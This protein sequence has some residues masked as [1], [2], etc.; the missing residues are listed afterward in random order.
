MSGGQYDMDPGYPAVEVDDTAVGGRDTA[1]RGH[2]Y[3]SQAREAAKSEETR[4][5]GC[6]AGGREQVVDSA[7][8]Y[9]R[10]A[11]RLRRHGKLREALDL[12][13]RAFEAFPKDDKVE[14]TFC[15][16]LTEVVQAADDELHAKAIG[17][18]RSYDTTWARRLLAQYERPY[19]GRRKPRRDVVPE[20]LGYRFD[21]EHSTKSPPVSPPPGVS[22]P[23]PPVPPRGTFAV[24]TDPSVITTQEPSQ[25]RLRRYPGSDSQPPAPIP[26]PRPAP[27]PPTE[28]PDSS[29]VPAQTDMRRGHGRVPAG[30][31]VG[32]LLGALIGGLVMYAAQAQG[33]VGGLSVLD[34][35]LRF[36][37]RQPQIV[38]LWAVFGA[39][40]GLGVVFLNQ[41]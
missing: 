41:Q 25:R 10:K 28:R 33:D 22:V 17:M 26:A 21:W 38:G 36:V 5:E 14:D 12:L 19:E 11:T 16:F 18:L 37:P 39:L 7:E 30:L 27:Q 34:F 13:E 15:A 6:E 23:Q 20:P 31:I 1:R 29:V 35:L 3:R 4:P 8:G 40:G 9:C 24:A 32:A 2:L